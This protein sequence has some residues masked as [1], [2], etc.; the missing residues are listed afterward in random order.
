MEPARLAAG[1]DR[2]P[3]VRPA[4]SSGSLDLQKV[5][6]RLLVALCVAA[7]AFGFVVETPADLLRGTVAILTSPSN[8]TTDYMAIASVGATFL[9]AGALTLLSVVLVRRER[10][11]FS[12]PIIAGL[13]TVFGFALFGK[14]L[15]NSVPIT[16]GVLLYAR[17]DH[18]RFRDYQV[19]SLFATSLGPAV[20]FMAFGKDLPL[21]LGILL[22]YL[23]GVVIGL[24]VPPLS[25]HFKKF[26]H[27]LSLYNVGFTAGIVGM[28]VVA[29]MNLLDLDVVEAS[30]VSTGHTLELAVL[31]F[32]FCAALLVCGFV[33]NGRSVRGMLGLMRRSGQ[34]P[35]DFVALEGVGR[36]VMNMGLVGVMAV[37]YVLA[38]GGELNGPVLGAVFTVIGFGAFGKHPRN[39]LPVLAGVALASVLTSTDIGSTAAVLAALF[40][41]TLAPISGVFGSVWGV[42]A[43]VM[44]LAIVANVGFLH[45]GMNLYNQGFAAGFVAIVLYPVLHTMVG[46]RAKHAARSAHR[47]RRR[48]PAA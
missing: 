4:A 17:L 45:A 47:R 34:A 7:M 23:L 2:A 38:V 8:L 31:T 24:V 16:L 20:S 27:G 26:H 29:V 15:F 13:F 22:G 10:T 44:H 37:T 14:N 43:G 6:F 30:Y 9:N 42:V 41:T 48:A 36:T 18:K 35:T 33:L 3:D 46:I 25:E 5:K 40:G 28:V 21:W 11:E 19:E 1:A 39:C 12:G 32:T